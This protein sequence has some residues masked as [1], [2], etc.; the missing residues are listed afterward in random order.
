MKVILYFGS[1]NP[2]H[3]GHIALAD[4]VSKQFQAPVW[5]VLSPQ[6]PFKQDQNLWNE[7]LRERLLRESLLAHP[8]LEFCDAELQLPKPSYT[9]NT[10]QYL[11]KRHPETE[12]YILMGQ[13]N[14]CGLHRW[15]EIDL[16]LSTCRV[17]VY[18]RKETAPQP[19]TYPILE[20]FSAKITLLNNLPLLDI[21]SSL[22]RQKLAQGEDISGLVPWQ[23]ALLRPDAL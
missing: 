13:D 12:F 16:I 20:R 8:S 17:L 18:P 5:F 19:E 11:Q 1:F 3:N 7:R 2:V 10:L 9:V 6:N 23:T 15:K 4:A 22:I 14:L 21:S